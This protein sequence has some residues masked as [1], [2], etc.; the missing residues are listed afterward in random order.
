MDVDAKVF[1]LPYE[2]V[3]RSVNPKY[4]KRKKEVW[5]LLEEKESEITRK[6]YEIGKN[7]KDYPIQ[8]KQKKYSSYGPYGTIKKE[9]EGYQRDEKEIYYYREMKKINKLILTDFEDISMLEIKVN[10]KKINN[11]LKEK[12]IILSFPSQRPDD[13]TLDITAF[14]LQDARG[15]SFSLMDESGTYIKK[16]IMEKKKGIVREK[17]K[18][19]DCL[20]KMVM[21]KKIKTTKNIDHLPYIEVVKKEKKY[22]YRKIKYKYE[23]EK[24]RIYSLEKKE[25][26]V[27]VSKLEKIAIYR[28]E[29]LEL[30]DTIFLDGYLDID[31]IVKRTTI[32]LKEIKIESSNSCGKTNLTISYHSFSYQ[33]EA[34]IT[35]PVYEESKVVRHY[36]NSYLFLVF[37]NLLLTIPSK[38]IF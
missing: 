8:T 2:K 38:K 5:Y 16:T 14:I 17:I 19:I 23:K 12:E 35:C 29:Q 11:L 4:E 27:V 1:S 10:G 21:D 26:Y 22:R 34:F 13:I 31:K 24:Q 33:Q 25:G 30:F 18:V 15:P 9:I 32:P 20:N 28:R 36:D 3:E 37:F 7:P 6:Y